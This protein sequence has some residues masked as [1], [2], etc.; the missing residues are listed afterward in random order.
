MKQK[1][2]KIDKALSRPNMV[3]GDLKR[4]IQEVIEYFKKK[5]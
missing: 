5:F 1:I 2:K 3:F 4:I